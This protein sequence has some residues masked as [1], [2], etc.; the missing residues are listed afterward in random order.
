MMR[1]HPCRLL[2]EDS[3][4]FYGFGRFEHS[5]TNFQNLVHLKIARQGKT[6]ISQVIKRVV[7]TIQQLWRNFSD[8]FHSARY[9]D[10]DWMIPIHGPQKIEHYAPLRVVIVHFNFF[11]NDS[12]LFLNSLLC[13]V[14]RL[15]KVQQNLQR[16][17]QL[18]GA[19]EKVTSGFKRG[20]RVGIGSCFGVS[21]EGVPFFA[22][23]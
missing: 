3:F 18:I 14:R 21:F 16:F 20:E 2:R 9:I 17:I 1:Y 8:T 23:K 5:V 13:K 10:P 12:L 19:G 4:D 15:Y 11:S 6:H 7:A 22:L